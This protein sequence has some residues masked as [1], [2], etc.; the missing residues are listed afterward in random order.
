MINPL[1]K[2][3]KDEINRSEDIKN[4]LDEH[5][6]D[7]HESEREEAKVDFLEEL[8]EQH[9]QELIEKVVHIIDTTRNLTAKEQKPLTTE[10]FNLFQ[11]H[12]NAEIIRLFEEVWNHT[13]QNVSRLQ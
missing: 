2:S 3:W 4:E 5:I 8:F 12:D 6:S 13:N 9:Q 11:V 10:I 1:R 7:Y